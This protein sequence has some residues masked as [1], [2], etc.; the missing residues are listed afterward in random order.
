[1][2]WRRDTFYLYGGVEPASGER[3]FWEFSHLDTVWFQ[4]FVDLFAQ[5]YPDTLNLVPLD[6]GAFHATASLRWLAHVVPVFQ[7]PHSPQ[8]NS[9]ERLWQYLKQRLQWQSFVNLDDLKLKLES[10]LAELSPA[11]IAS[12]CG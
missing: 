1:M 6:H 12:L 11:I 3:F 10:L 4:T 2:S 7:P 9:T 8:L 5:Q